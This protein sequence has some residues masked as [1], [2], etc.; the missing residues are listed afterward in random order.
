MLT[1]T[2]GNI[3]ILFHPSYNIAIVM[4]TSTLFDAVAT[5]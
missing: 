1:N 5:I 4:T 2:M 3:A